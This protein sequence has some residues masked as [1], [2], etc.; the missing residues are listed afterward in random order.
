MIRSVAIHCGRDFGSKYRTVPRADVDTHLRLHLDASST[1]ALRSNLIAELPLPQNL[2]SCKWISRCSSAVTRPPGATTARRWCSIIRRQRL[3]SAPVLFNVDAETGTIM[4]LWI[5][6]RS[7]RHWQEG[8]EKVSRSRDIELSAILYS[9]GEVLY[10][11]FDIGDGSWLACR[12]SMPHPI[13]ASYT[14]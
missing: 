2:G 5:D 11:R 14:A 10:W 9:R 1:P 6:T 13:M 12:I 7:S 8:K 4:P 3:D